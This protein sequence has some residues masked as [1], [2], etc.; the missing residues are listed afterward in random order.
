MVFPYT[1]VQEERGGRTKAEKKIVWN[2]KRWLAFAQQSAK[3]MSKT[4]RSQESNYIK[5]QKEI[6]F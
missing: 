6:N 4:N 2:W 3:Q 1:Y 5:M